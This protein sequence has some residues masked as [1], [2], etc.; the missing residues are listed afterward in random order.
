VIEQTGPGGEVTGYTTR[1]VPIISPSR[2]RA[3]PEARAVVIRRYLDPAIGRPGVFWRQRS[4]PVP[5]WLTR[6]HRSV[7]RLPVDQS[8]GRLS[9]PE[10]APVLAVVDARSGEAA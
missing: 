4:L 1:S 8:P 5:G 7:T 6:W 3:L 10:S 9:Q 2:L